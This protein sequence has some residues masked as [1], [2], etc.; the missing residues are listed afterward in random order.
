MGRVQSV[1]DTSMFGFSLLSATL[2]SFLGQLVR[3]DIL[4]GLCGGLIVL[5]G[6]LS[7]FLLPAHEGQPETAMVAENAGDLHP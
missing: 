3:V 2:A 1:L 5:A 6:I 7:F 4:F